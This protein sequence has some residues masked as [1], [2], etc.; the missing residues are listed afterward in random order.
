M[1]NQKK[2]FYSPQFSELAS[3]SIRRLAWA[4]HMPMTSTID[5]M[6]RLIPSVVDAGKVCLACKDKTKCKNCGFRNPPTLQEKTAIL[7][8][9]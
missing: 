6:V 8:A 2:Q 1:D 9:L 4:L 7:A 3:V 5:L